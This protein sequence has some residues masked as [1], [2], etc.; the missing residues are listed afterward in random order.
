MKK[1]VYSL[2]AKAKVSLPIDDKE[3]QG[4]CS[5]CTF[6]L[7]CTYN[8]NPERPV[9]QC[10]EFEGI[11][12]SSDQRNKPKNV[13]PL[14]FTTSP[15]PSGTPSQDYK[16]L[17]TTCEERATCTYPKPEGGVWHCEEFR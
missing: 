17:C 15:L 6:A 9:L 4:L 7:A 8:R 16:G 5:C 12:Y 2:K 3:Y 11:V 10:E 13:L 1:S 14:N